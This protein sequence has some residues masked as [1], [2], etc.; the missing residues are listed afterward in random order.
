MSRR[1]RK[2]SERM[3][4]KSVEAVVSVGSASFHN[5]HN[6]FSDLALLYPIPLESLRFLLVEYA[7]MD[8][9][10]FAMVNAKRIGGATLSCV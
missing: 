4:M 9:G 5:T 6:R 3:N 7:L 2:E 1:C 10:S 8:W